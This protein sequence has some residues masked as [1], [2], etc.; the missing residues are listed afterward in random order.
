MAAEVEK[1]RTKRARAANKKRGE[2]TRQLILETAIELFGRV[3]PRQAS[4]GKIAQ[5]AGVALGTVPYHFGSMNELVLEVLRERD[6]RV[7]VHLAPLFERGGLEGLRLLPSVGV[8]AR[9]APGLARLQV[10]V[11]AEAIDPEHFANGFIR[12]RYRRVRA[13]FEEAVQHGVDRGEIRDDVDTTHVANSIL[14]FMDGITLHFAID[15]RV[16]I[17]RE[18]EGF[19]RRLLATLAA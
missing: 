10:M 18:Y 2:R 14:A 4:L 6:R 7:A 19:T 8:V 9:D 11:A 13:A 16:D 1:K 15:P 12:R 3:G 5:A 17:V